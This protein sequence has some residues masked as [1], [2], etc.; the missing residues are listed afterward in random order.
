KVGIGF[1]EGLFRRNI[2]WRSP[3][4]WG[5]AFAN[6]RYAFR[7]P[8]YDVAPN[9]IRLATFKLI[10]VEWMESSPDFRQLEGYPQH[11]DEIM[12]VAE[13]DWFWPG[14]FA[15]IGKHWRYEFEK[16]RLLGVYEDLS[17]ATRCWVIVIDVKDG[18]AVKSVMTRGIGNNG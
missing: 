7:N 11:V 14:R 2:F 16:S 12:S 15:R 18:K 10:I 5:N 13:L 1:S 3:S 8:R 6:L 4:G 17:D 9:G